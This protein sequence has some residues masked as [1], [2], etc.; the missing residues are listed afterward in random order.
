MIE[1]T[2]DFLKRVW[3]DIQRLFF[4][5]LIV[6]ILSI[7]DD[8]FKFGD[9]YAF[10]TAVLSSTSIVLTVAGISHIIRRILFPSIDLKEFA[11]EALRKPLSSAIVFLGVCIVLSTFIVVNVMLLS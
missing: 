6:V 4:L 8:V 5:F 3:V 10:L 11:R 1:T 9:R 7:V 2:V